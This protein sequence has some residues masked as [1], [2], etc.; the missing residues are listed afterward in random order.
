[1]LETN[2]LLP[3]IIL[4]GVSGAIT[5]L[6]AL[7]KIKI[8][9]TFVLEIIAGIILGPFLVKYFLNNDFKVIT[10]FLYVI[11]FSFIMFLSGYDVNLEVF[12]D[13]KKTTKNHINILK[14]SL[15]MIGLVYVA[16]LVASIF[17]IGE[18]NKVV[19]G[20]ILLT[21]TLSSTFAG[22]VVPLV[23][24]EKL[25]GTNWGKFVATF[26]F[27]NELISV[28]LLTVFMIV[29]NM[30]LTSLINYL[31]IIG[32]FF[33]IYLILKVRRGRRMEEGMIFFS[34]KL[35][36]VAL[37]AAVYFGE[38][39]GGEYVLGAF[40]LGFLLRLIKVNHH[41]MQYLEGIGFGLFIPIFF[42]LLGMKIDIVNIFNNPS[43]ILMAVLLFVAFMVV[44][45]PVLYLLKW[46]QSKTVFA[47]VALVAVTLVVAVT[48]EHLGVHYE[49]FSHEFGQALVLASVLTTVIGPLIF[50]ISCFG[51]LRK[52]RAEEKAIGYEEDIKT[53]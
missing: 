42:V 52:I 50:Q 37:A 30:N 18:F 28:V 21:I 46:Y 24:T 38:L 31:I 44:K 19:L 9:P 3:I 36:I 2:F 1:M 43:I 5:V 4:L 16:G 41:K 53:A 40:L 11:G 34:T 39:G 27:L 23:S 12:K 20:V 22:V 45:L 8:L 26:S 47:T 51:P 10:D 49:I 13:R 29:S 32:V 6:V 25:L 48:A 35:I 17:F 7:F 33:L 14:T 15:L